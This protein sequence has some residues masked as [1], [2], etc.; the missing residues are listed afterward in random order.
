MTLGEKLQLLRKQHGWTQEELAQQILVSRQAL[1]KWESDTAVPD[2]EN[3][4]ALSRLFQ[5]STDYLLLDEEELAE[6]R[7]EG[8]PPESPIDRETAAGPRRHSYAI[9][10]A[11]CLAGVS[12]LGM[13]ILGIFASVLHPVYII[14]PAGED[15][16][17]AYTGLLGFLKT[18]RLEWLF[19]LL[20]LTF[21]GSA[22]FVFKRTR[23]K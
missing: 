15:W 22:F 21:V 19:G 4:V 6:K 10:I 16:V 8:A 3:V 11:L 9:I 2:T 20:I 18:Y 17:H 14:A 23:K 1:S 13:L 7:P 12:L 5:V